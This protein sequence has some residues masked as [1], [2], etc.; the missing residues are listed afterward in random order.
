MATRWP[1]PFV[2]VVLASGDVSVYPLL[3]QET[4]NRDDNQAENSDGWERGVVL[5]Y[6]SG[7]YPVDTLGYAP[8]RVTL[9]A[10][11]IKPFIVQGYSPRGLG[12]S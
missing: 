8:A 5:C 4:G 11:F 1:V 12:R 10:L 3:F 6:G 9:A 7:R 2:L